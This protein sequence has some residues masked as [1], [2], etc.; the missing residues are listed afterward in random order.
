MEIRPLTADDAVSYQGLRLM[1]LTECPTAFASSHQEE[2]QRPIEQIPTFLSG[3]HERVILGAFSDR[4]L[5]GIV[6]I[7]REAQLKQRHKAFIRGMYVAPSH[8]SNGVGRLLLNA[9]LAIAQDWPEIT[10]VTLVVTVGN[11]AAMA[12]YRSLGF[13]A[14]GREPRALLVDGTYH[15]DIFMSRFL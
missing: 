13:K 7:G 11:H 6:G 12:L 5:I 14:Y 4:T 10:L 9:A 15:D 8:R 1:A 3:S 2:C